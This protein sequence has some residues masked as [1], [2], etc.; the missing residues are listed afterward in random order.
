MAA[1][2]CSQSCNEVRCRAPALSCRGAWTFRNPGFWSDWLQDNLS[3]NRKLKSIGG[4]RRKFSS[5]GVAAAA[6]PH[7]A[8][9]A[10]PP[11]TPSAFQSRI[12][13]AKVRCNKRHQ[14]FTL[15]VLYKTK[16]FAPFFAP[17][18][19]VSSR[20]RHMPPLI[21]HGAQPL[22]QTQ[23]AAASNSFRNFK[24]PA[25]QTQTLVDSRIA[26]RISRILRQTFLLNANSDILQRILL[27]SLENSNT[28][29]RTQFLKYYV[30]YCTV[31]YVRFSITRYSAQ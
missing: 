17:A 20:A 7:P 1:I 12:C 14:L 22:T 29:W 28:Y 18:P 16:P 25:K 24:N 30:D 9:G 8:A 26:P 13:D 6:V 27:M 23:L 31:V 2:C 10:G 5:Y 15:F 4:G 11:T 21:E 3:R 19:A